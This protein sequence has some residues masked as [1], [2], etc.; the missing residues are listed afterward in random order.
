MVRATDS[1]EELGF[2]Q[3][4]AKVF[5]GLTSMEKATV[6]DLYSVAK[7]PRSAVYG[8][9]D[10]LIEKGIVE[11]SQGKPAVYHALSPENA[12]Q[13]VET[14]FSKKA[15]KALGALKKVQGT[16]DVNMEEGEMLWFLNGH[17]NIM[18]RVAE[19]IKR[20]EK[21]IFFGMDSEKLDE[22]SHLLKDASDRGVDIRFLAREDLLDDFD[23]FK[24][25]A[26]PILLPRSDTNQTPD[27]GFVYIDGKRAIVIRYG[28][29]ENGRMESAFWSESP[30]FL[31]FIKMALSSVLK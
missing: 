31:S 15:E 4:E 19:C 13:K 24:P 21:S 14:E 27:M 29:T 22:F 2:T 10:R 18:D 30:T 12:L 23:S 5:A 7:V 26:E 25:L 8:I 20:A 9:L 17:E 16:V 11:V 3:Y 28:S 1:L 6:S